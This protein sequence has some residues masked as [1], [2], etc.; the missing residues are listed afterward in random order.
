MPQVWCFLCGLCVC[1]V[2]V[3]DGLPIPELQRRPASVWLP[4]AVRWRLGMGGSGWD[5]ASGGC[6]RT[7]AA[8]RRSDR[9]GLRFARYCRVSTETA[10]PVTRGRGSGDMPSAL[11]P[12]RHIV[13]G[14]KYFDFGG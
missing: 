11:Y 8:A 10:D 5:A 2:H 14:G 4:I 9:A 13:V 1:S 6:E 7:G 3:H 12:A